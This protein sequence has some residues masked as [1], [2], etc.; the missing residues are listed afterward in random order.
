MPRNFFLERIIQRAAPK[1]THWSFNGRN[2][3]TVKQKQKQKTHQNA[4]LR[5]VGNSLPRRKQVIKNRRTLNAQSSLSSLLNRTIVT[6]KTNEKIREASR[7]QKQT[8]A[9]SSWWASLLY[10][11][12]SHRQQNDLLLES[13]SSHWD[14]GKRRRI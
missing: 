4:S 5:H 10:T 14:R 1:R 11:S 6:Q 8:H 13:R 9:E 2:S 7:R 3:L 12:S